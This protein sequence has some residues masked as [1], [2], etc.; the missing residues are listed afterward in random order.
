MYMY[1]FPSYVTKCSEICRYLM[2]YIHITIEVWK[3]NGLAPRQCIKWP[4]PNYC[5][6]LVTNSLPTCCIFRIAIGRSMQQHYVHF[7]LRLHQGT[8][9][10]NTWDYRHPAQS[11]CG[12]KTDKWMK[13]HSPIWSV[14]FTSSVRPESLLWLCVKS[15]TFSK[16]SKEKRLPW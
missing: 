15:N 14:W 4:W 3:F 1:T 9:I 6:Q 11:W 12:I 8:F 5:S 16:G 2:H 10:Y 13:F 7:M